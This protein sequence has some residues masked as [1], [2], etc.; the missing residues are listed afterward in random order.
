MAQNK[1]VPQSCG[2]PPGLPNGMAPEIFLRPNFVASLA[3]LSINISP[4][5]LSLPE[6]P[7]Q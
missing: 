3:L 2:K 1:C 5:N 4:N 6:K 7:H